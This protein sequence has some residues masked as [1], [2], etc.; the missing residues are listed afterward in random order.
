MNCIEISL[1]MDAIK[2]KTI[3]EIAY[4]FYHIGTLAAVT[5]NSWS[6]KLSK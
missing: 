3:N 5:K 1:T 4:E 6:N 2:I